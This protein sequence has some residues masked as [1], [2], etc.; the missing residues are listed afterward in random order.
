M[1]RFVLLAHARSGSQLLLTALNQHP[2]VLAQSELLH[3]DEA[4]RRRDHRAAD[5]SWYLDGEDG[6]AFV[7][8]ILAPRPDRDA[9]G[10]KLFYEAAQ[11]GAARSAWQ[12]LAE[13]RE[14][15]VVHLERARRLES[16]VSLALAIASSEWM[17]HRAEG[18]APREREPIRLSPGRVQR[19]LDRLERDQRRALSLLAGRPRLDLEYTQL[20][21]RYP[22][23]IAAVFE[24]LGVSAHPV[25][26]LL[27]KQATRPLHEQLAN[28]DELA[29]HFA[30]TPYARHFSGG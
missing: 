11:E 20:V 13:D 9:I 29:R 4:T 14:L 12:A 22:E 23:T 30:G 10:F 6:A 7:R 5:G 15:R 24:F 25:E 26:Q 21:E 28:F 17:L 19:Y 18:R 16:L 1:S 2:R 3:H 8:K 27:V